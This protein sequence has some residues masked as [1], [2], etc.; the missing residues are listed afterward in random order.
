MDKTA[1][2]GEG[3]SSTGQRLV[4]A[5]KAL[6]GQNA[7]LLAD[8]DLLGGAVHLTADT[9]GDLLDFP[10]RLQKSFDLCV[11]RGAGFHGWR[12]L[13]FTVGCFYAHDGH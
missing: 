2:E 5:S 11:D 13:G 9:F 10:A 12:R 1:E 8:G 7:L 3:Q 4:I 6:R